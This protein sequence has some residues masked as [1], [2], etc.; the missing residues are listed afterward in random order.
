M[1]GLLPAHSGFVENTMNY[2]LLLDLAVD[3]GYE[4][5]MSG[6]ETFRVEET[7]FRVLHS[8]DIE[9][10]VFAIPNYLIVSIITDEGKP[11]TRMRRI[12]FHG[13]DLDAVEKY[14]GLSR[15][16]CNR[17]PAPEEAAKWLD[18]TRKSLV[19]YSFPA[20]LLGNFMGGSGFSILFGC[21]L[22]D[23]LLAG[24]C[25]LIV[26]LV[27]SFTG[28]M[29]VNPFFSTM[30]AAFLMSCCAYCMQLLGLAGNVDGVIIGALMMLVPGLLFT[31]AMRDI[32][33]GDI[34]SGVNRIVQV[35][36]LAVAIAVGTAVGW[37]LVNTCLGT[38]VSLPALDNS[39][40]ATCI[41]SAVGCIG[42]AILFNIHGPGGLLC[43]L[44]GVL[45]WAIY[46]ITVHTGGSEILAYLFGAVFSSLYA[47][48]MARVRKYPA[49]SYLVVSVF[50]LIPGAGVYYAMN[51]A[52]R[53]EMENFAHQGM[54]TAAIAGV[55]AIGILLVSTLVRLYYTWQQMKK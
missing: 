27:N 52:V 23:S 13:N 22:R 53:G 45:T 5:A 20:V 43:A 54:H 51:Y 36:L 40:I 3:L 24:I 46:Y 10:E 18:V 34:N 41:G 39:L 47:E 48:I 19:R 15:A 8:Y 33:Y 9:A 29:K 2:Y 12:G 6:A 26:G 49:I 38:P 28:C 42:F 14:N 30:A 32:I 11:I 35:V 44:G 21:S 4:L 7:I 31:N 25:G 1:P 55:M 37:N 50:P 17:K 16:L